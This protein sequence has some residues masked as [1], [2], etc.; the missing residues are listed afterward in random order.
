MTAAELK[1]YSPTIFLL[2][3]LSL[4][5]SCYNLVNAS[6]SLCAMATLFVVALTTSGLE[7]MSSH[8]CRNGGLEGLQPPNILLYIKELTVIKDCYL[9]NY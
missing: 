1:T 3:T 2:S 9:T 6:L 8:K 4:P 5:L 7:L